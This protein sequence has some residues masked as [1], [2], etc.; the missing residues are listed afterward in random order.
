MSLCDR[1]RGFS[2]LSRSWE[3]QPV[4]QN[5]SS[6]SAAY[7]KCMTVVVRQHVYYGSSK[8]YSHKR[9]TNLLSW[10]SKHKNFNLSFFSFMFSE[11]WMPFF[12]FLF[13]F[14]YAVRK[15]FF[16]SCVIESWFRLLETCSLLGGLMRCDLVFQSKF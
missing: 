16:S 8:N 10:Y 12:S 5:L 7:T 9:H 15:L 3:T 4:W 6:F 1:A 14:L 13:F 11:N 2:C